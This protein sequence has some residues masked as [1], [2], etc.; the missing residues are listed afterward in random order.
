MKSCL[1]K[2]SIAVLVAG[3]AAIALAG[4]AHA[5]GAVNNLYAAD[6]MTIAAPVAPQL[7]TATRQ[8]LTRAMAG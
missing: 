6:K 7:H 3:A 8:A 2:S 4:R 1:V 5:E